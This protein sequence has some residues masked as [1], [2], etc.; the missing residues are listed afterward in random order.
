MNPYKKLFLRKDYYI[1][2]P[3]SYKAKKSVLS[4]YGEDL[5]LFAEAKRKDETKADDVDRHQRE[6]DGS[7][8]LGLFDHWLAEGSVNG[9][10]H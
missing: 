1:R 6:I 4:I 8:T 7:R 9:E 2:V 10:E 3:A 5:D